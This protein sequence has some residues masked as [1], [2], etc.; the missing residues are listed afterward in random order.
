MKLLPIGTEDFKKIIE[1]DLYYVDKTSAISLIERNNLDVLLF[2]RPRRFG[3]TLFISMLD[4]FY[5]IE[6]KEENKNLFK[7]LDISKSEYMK[8]QGSYPVISLTVKDIT[9]PNFEIL[10]AKI[11]D[12][13][14]PLIKKVK[15]FKNISKEDLNILDRMENCDYSSLSSAFY[16]FTRLYYE[17]YDKKVIFLMDEYEAPILNAYQNGYID[18]AIQF[19]STLY[20]SVL[21]TNPYLE[22]A[23]ITGITR[24]T[25]SNIFLGLNNI[26]VY[27]I[28]SSEFSDSF[29]FTSREVLASLKEYGLNNYKD[30]VKEYYD[31]YIFGKTE[32]YNPWSIL[33]FLNKKELKP[34]WTMTASV[35]IISSLLKKASN[36]IKKTF[37]S[38]LDGE[39]VNLKN[40]NPN[41]LVISD[42][43]D[44][45]KLFAYMITTGYLTYDKNGLVRVVNKEILSSISDLSSDGLYNVPTD[46]IG[47]KDSLDTGDLKD[48]EIYLNSIFDDT[49]SYMDMPRT[50]FEQSYHLALGTLLYAMGLGKV[51][52]NLEAGSGRYDIILRNF[53]K[54]RYSYVFEVKVAKD[55]NEIGAKLDEGLDQIK[56]NNYIKAISDYSKK[57]IVC[58]CFYKKEIHMKF[59]SIK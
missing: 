50:A 18:E 25:Q 42:L 24:I 8:L 16:T 3:K 31:G 52:S 7:N 10:L 12:K 38:L 1:K 44:Y 20:S 36:H 2:T 49:F 14:I 6:S 30:G 43:D 11:R 46:F 57:M 32:I 15:T 26:R 47:F 27:G 17:N 53:N 33:N 19:F 45:N 35:K 54:D 51:K 5:N 9:A 39:S 23:I 22:R 59:E 21:K 58:F 34:Y 55:E 4:Y 28:D 13:L 29:G 56:K 40:T 37:I 48:A 41:N